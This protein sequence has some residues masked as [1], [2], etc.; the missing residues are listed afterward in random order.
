MLTI[1]FS[2]KSLELDY[3]SSVVSLICNDYSIYPSAL[4]IQYFVFVIYVLLRSKLYIS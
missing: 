3:N 4:C 2:S 1:H